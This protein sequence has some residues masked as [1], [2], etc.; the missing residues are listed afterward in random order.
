M[1]PG[2]ISSLISAV[3]PALVV[4]WGL[5]VLPLFSALPALAVQARAA[6]AAGGHESNPLV[7]TSAERAAHPD[8]EKSEAAV[9]DLADRLK[10]QNV[11]LAAIVGEVLRLARERQ[12]IE[13]ETAVM[14]GRLRALL[15]QLWALDVRLKGMLNASVAPWDE[16]DRD[17]TWLGAVYA[18]A[19][20]DL[21]RLRVKKSE[22]AANLTREAGLK[23][24]VDAQAVQI[25]KTKDDLLAGRLK[26][27][28]ELSNMRR[29]HPTPGD[30]LERILEFVDQ[31]DFSPTGV[32]G[33]PAV[34]AK[35]R[36]PWPVKGKQTTDFDP[37]ASPPRNGVQLACA[38]GAAVRAVY[39]G[40]VAFAGDVPGLGAVVVVG[41]GDG[42]CSVYGGLARVAVAPGQEVALGEELGT[43][44]EHAPV[45]G[46]GMS[47]ELRFGGKPINPDRWLLPG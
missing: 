12:A 27:W 28:R 33:R 45:T 10:A 46:A 16:T 47:F 20:G 32:Q 39:L 25:E 34:A 1:P 8:I 17:L 24:Q 31:A 35:G 14:T 26:L 21:D 36:L 5:T 19:R 18:Q 44:G 43:V 7:A 4:V 3:L 30:R 13:D 40:R 37:A 15:P 23:P 9:R 6:D 2:L 38:R 22:L 41:H 29:E 42:L 11:R